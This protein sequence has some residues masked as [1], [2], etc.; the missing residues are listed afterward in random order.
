[1][2]DVVSGVVEEVEVVWVCEGVVG[3][4]GEELWT[5]KVETRRHKQVLD[6]FLAAYLGM[7]DRHL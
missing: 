3:G 7:P 6:E 1:M 4:V 5:I 2:G